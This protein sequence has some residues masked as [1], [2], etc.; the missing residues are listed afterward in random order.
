V[1][2]LRDAGE[3]EA[4]RRLIAARAADP[5]VVVGPGDDAAVLRP[6]PGMDLVATTD[7]FVEG[8][9]YLPE[10]L[11]PA[12]LGGRL[13][14]ANLSDL[15][16]MA[17][18]PRWALLSIGA[19]ADHEV[20]ALEALE[21]GLEQALRSEGAVVVGGNIA[22]TEGPE[23]LSLTLLGEVAP[24][25]AWARRGARP[26]DLIAASGAPGRAGAGLRLA[27]SLGVKGRERV[28]A[29]WQ[30]LVDAWLAPRA[31]VAL[32]RMLAATGA[33]TAA[34]DL[35]DGLLGDLGQLCR[36]SAVGAEI[37]G[38][39]GGSDPLLARA[40]K[41]LDVDPF[42][43]WAGPSDDYE[44]LLA[45]DPSRRAACELAAE[46][47]GVALAF[48]GGCTDASGA[49]ERLDGGSRRTLDP[50]GFDHFARG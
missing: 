25:R 39:A 6:E 16:A 49:I 22:A 50:T 32:A 1:P 8:R 13:A 21:H 10:W 9:H 43:L 27:R 14:A 26:G 5:T 45:V 33:V 40:A 23:W 46:A 44:L 47:A 48:I 20:E 3:L 30:A 31:R 36:A 15:A 2:R 29:E 38:E 42:D 24:G 12:G 4:L 17:A 35:S 7:A 41:T 28:P 19:R 18:E 11:A 34:I 37:R